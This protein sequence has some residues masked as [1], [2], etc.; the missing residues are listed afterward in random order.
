MVYEEHTIY[1]DGNNYFI[2]GGIILS[3]ETLV[4]HKELMERAIVGKYINPRKEKGL[5]KLTKKP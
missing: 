3:D 5:L 1:Y 4:L 2:E